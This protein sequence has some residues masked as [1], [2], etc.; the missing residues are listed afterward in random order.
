MIK[1]YLKIALR[2]LFRNRIFSFVN[3]GGLA[4]GIAVALIIGLWVYDELSFN[5]S[6]KNY[7]YITE[8]KAHADY[9]GELF[10]INSHP[11]PL[12]GEL[13][14]SYGNDFTYVVMSTATEKHDLSA[15]DKHFNE[16]GMYMQADAPHMLTLDMQQGNR[17]GLKDHSGI[18]LSAS[19]ATKLFGNTDPLDKT[20]TIDNKFMAKITGIYRDFPPNS[21]FKEVAFI[22]PFDFYLSCY[23]QVRQRSTNWNSVSV[24][25]YAQLNRGTD[26]ASASSRIKNVLAARMTGDAARR[27]PELFLHPMSKWHLHGEFEHGVNITSQPLKL[28]WIYSV[29]GILVLL[30]A[31]INFMNLST[32]RSEKRA[33]EVGIRK[34][35]GSSRLGLVKQF[36]GE[37]IL[38]CS[39][40]FV[41][42]LVL[43]RLA[44]PWFNNIAAKEID[45]PWGNP[46]FWIVSGVF[47]FVTGLIAG[48]YPAFYLSSFTPIK[49]LKGPFRTGRLAAIPRKALVVVQFTASIML[50]IGTTVIYRQVQF[51]RNRPVGYDRESLLQV[52]LNS[53]EYQEKYD[54]IRNELAKTG[55]V[56]AVAASASP[57][58][59]I[60][61][62]ATGLSWQGKADE[63]HMEFATVAVTH[64]YG[65]TVRWQFVAGRDF[66][67][68]LASDSLG[69]VINEAA[70]KQMG[71][72]DPIGQSIT[73]GQAA[74]QSFRI[75]GMV[76]DMVMESPYAQVFPTIFFIYDREP[77]NCMFIRLIPDVAAKKAI[78]TVENTIRKIVPAAPIDYSFV[79]DD[80]NSK[81]A[82]EEKASQLVGAF[83]V[84][85]IVISCL[86]LF[87]LAS[88]LSEQRIKEI[89]IRKVLGASVFG[90]WRLLSVEF[91]I[92]VLIALLVA[93]PLAYYFM[94]NWLSEYSY[95]TNLSW[96]IFA[97][98]GVAALLVTLSTVSFQ[99]IKAAIANPVKSLRTE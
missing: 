73:W 80:F 75:I 9:N 52:E 15:G 16:P 6:H 10:T 98:A 1:N 90:L 40:A 70:A 39:I 33:K 72:M 22:A 43:T 28:V 91:M 56:S 50:I 13:K 96:W 83:A 93:S 5:T 88:F 89:G 36:L 8:L 87:G 4:V 84:L 79:D 49:V 17:N 58:T 64:D 44:M 47:V 51:A 94:N 38:N 46:A 86:G 67:K 61:S 71:L 63:K 68:D 30:L 60:W 23:E 25:I 57:L 53:A 62:T 3:I 76:K 55:M 21:D 29:I 31:C 42:A 74:N 12:A 59:S 48:S 14:T 11:I 69:F 85:A 66:S 41:V 34:S 99:S 95:R 37:S 81:F 7:H 20:I 92:L 65:K 26:V 45:I 2:N 18:I 54:V 27:K 19:L 77:M 32:A 97:G 82:A 24:K 35:I 78:P